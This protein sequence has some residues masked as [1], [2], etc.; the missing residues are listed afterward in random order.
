[1]GHVRLREACAEYR[2]HRHGE[3][4]RKR[5]EECVAVVRVHFGED[6]SYVVACDSVEVCVLDRFDFL[7]AF[8]ETPP[9]CVL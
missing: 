4:C 8:E 1:M 7:V 5:F 3:E 9:E 6:E 2:V